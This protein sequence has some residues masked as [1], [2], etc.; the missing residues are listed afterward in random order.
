MK[1][2]F[3]IENMTC[4]NCANK[5]KNALLE[6]AIPCEINVAR[7]SVAVERNGDIVTTSRRIITELGYKIL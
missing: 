4:E 2:I 7:K 1:H 6:M 5:I 3:I